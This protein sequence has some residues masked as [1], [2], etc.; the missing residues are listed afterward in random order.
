MRANTPI[1]VLAKIAIHAED[2]EAFRK[3]VFAEP[4]IKRGTASRVCSVAPHLGPIV[5][6]MVNGEEHFVGFAAAATFRPAICG[7]DFCPELGIQPI[8]LLG[9][10]LP[11]YG[12]L[13]RRHGSDGVASPLHRLCLIGFALLGAVVPTVLSVPFLVALTK[14]R[15]VSGDTWLASPRPAVRRGVEP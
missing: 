9:F 14:V 1:P 2:L 3:P 8:G 10:G 13:L 11:E 6:D 4:L 12:Q 7:E 5:P 15:L